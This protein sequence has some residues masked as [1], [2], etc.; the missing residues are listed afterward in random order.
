VG[1]C[2]VAVASLGVT[3][4][5]CTLGPG[6]RATAATFYL[7]TAAPST[8]APAA[9]P[10]GR[11]TTFSTPRGGALGVTSVL[12]KPAGS[13]AFLSMSFTLVKG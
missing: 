10:A 11:S 1:T 4:S 5:G 12:T 2:N 13:A 9:W 7:S 8:C 3:I 6:W